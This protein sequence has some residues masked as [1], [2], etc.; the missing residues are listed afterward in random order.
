MTP[1]SP[2]ERSLD[3]QDIL[4]VFKNAKDA[5]RMREIK[6]SVVRLLTPEGDIFNERQSEIEN[7]IERIIKEDK[8]LGKDSELEYKSG[9]YHKRKKVAPPQAGLLNSNYTGAAGECAV[10]S[11]LLF[12][13]Y[14][15]N[16]MMVDEGVDIV[17]VKENIYYYIQVKTTT[18]KANGNISCQI[19]KTRHAQ[20][21]GN[22]MRYYIV[23][24]TKDS[25]GFNQNLFFKI[26]PSLIDQAIYNRCI[27]VGEK[28]NVKIKF[29]PKTGEPQLYDERE[30]P[31]GF[32]LNNFT[33]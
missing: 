24:R 25:K 19:D 6:E 23:A 5:K 21:I 3:I 27:S 7:E 17:A 18:V 20:Y 32:Y 22:Q 30:M 28:I 8:K 14:N 31:I 11:E 2:T 13:G 4:A 29:N 16:R 1:S 15:V 26:D 12:N 9:R 33:L 10:M